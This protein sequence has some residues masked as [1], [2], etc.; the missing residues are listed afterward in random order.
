METVGMTLAVFGMTY[1]QLDP[2][3]SVAWRVGALDIPR[4]W[5]RMHRDA[6]PR[7]G[8]IAIF[9][10]WFAGAAIFCR[11]FPG[12]SVMLA[13]ASLVFAVS[14][15]DDLFGLP[16]WLRLFFQFVAAS[17]A[18]GG[19]GELSG[20]WSFAALAWVVALTN[21][22][23]FID[24]LD[25]LFAG[26]AAAEGAGL[27]FMLYGAGYPAAQA[28]LLL[29]AACLA[30]RMKNRAPAKLFSGDCGSGTVGFLLAV[31]SLH[32]GAAVPRTGW[33]AVSLVFA[34]PLA[35][36]FAAV[37]RRSLRGKSVFL[38]DRGHFHHRL[39]ATGLS[40]AVCGRILIGLSASAVL[41]GVLLCGEETLL[42]AAGACLWTVAL[43]IGL[44][45]FVLRAANR[46][47]NPE[48]LAKK[49]DF[50]GRL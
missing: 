4:D 49:V 25:G 44:R 23:N 1:F 26:C 11:A 38:P 45:A 43:L 39:A 31:L 15:A 47:G 48:N 18:V 22:H 41:I 6:V 20:W 29:A 16:A 28:P 32:A 3:I 21:A 46:D 37:L 17:L 30:F 34:Y 7:V 27:F 50:H 42:P 24:G 5:R 19:I 35:D 14:L 8:G 10:G 13:G 40:Q 36:L 33:L 2:L 12:L 9:F